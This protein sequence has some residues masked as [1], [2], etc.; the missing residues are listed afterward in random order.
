MLS[1]KHGRLDRSKFAGQRNLSFRLGILLVA[2]VGFSTIALG[3]TGELDRFTNEYP[4]AAKR[5]EERFAKVKGSARLWRVTP[6]DTR[7]QRAELAQF[8]VDHSYEKVT[9]ERSF[10]STLKISPHLDLV[11][12]VG[13]D[14]T[15]HLERFPGAKNFSVQGTGETPRDRAVYG[16][17]F[18][19]FLYAPYGIMT[20][21]LTKL[22]AS[23]TFHV[24]NAEPLT[25]DGKS[26]IK[27]NFE[28]GTLEPR[29][30]VSAVFDPDA[31]WIIRSS[32][33]HSNRSFGLH[34]KVDV[35]YGAPK[36]GFFLPNRVT[37]RDNGETSICEF[38]AWSF[39]PTPENEFSMTFYGLPDLIAKANAKRIPLYYW[40][41]GLAA[42]VLVF[43]VIL[44]W[45]S[46]R[47]G[48]VS[49][50]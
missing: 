30:Q 10:P 29:D 27:V 43:A 38:D 22:M 3:G 49:T 12:C 24:M 15:F 1:R 8:A 40:L 11:Y 19:R 7:P 26:L 5:L 33:Y 6:G 28:I 31:G 44:G 21:Q 14:S 46:S 17:I 37:F 16:T 39:E 9:I 45:L 2:W 36:D 48:K 41:G 32:E 25:K 23:P 35:E 20:V 50:T 34:V 42:V 47:R 18:G 4:G 13:K